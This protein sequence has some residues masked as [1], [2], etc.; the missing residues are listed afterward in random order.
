MASKWIELLKEGKLLSEPQLKI[1]CERVKEILMEESNV[2]PVS[3]P[4][5][6]CGD[7]HGQFYDL[8][9]LFR[10]GGEIPSNRYV[11]LGDYVDRGYHSVETF[12]Y[13][14]CLKLMFPG[15]ITLLRGN[16]ETRYI[17]QQYGMYLEV[18]KK[19]GNSNPWKYFTDLFDYL[20]MAAIIEGK[21]FCVHG[22]LSPVISCMDQI[23][24]I[25][26]FQELPT[27][28]PF[29]DLLWSDP[30]ERDVDGWVPSNRG[31]GWL[32]GWKV[33][34]EF[35]YLNDLDLICRSHQLVMEGFKTY[36]RDNNLLTVWSA[37]NYT[38][39]MGNKA[40]IMKVDHNLEKTFEF[41]SA[42]PRSIKS[43]PPQETLPYFL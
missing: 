39:R 15:H 25:N 37:P 17:S 27:E 33:V 34:K 16:H 26:R 5:V 20:P 8:L 38:Y 36:F 23:R 1:L 3:A 14:L 2:Q 22:G 40:T 9:E 18:T 30:E 6:I 11:F 7:I 42:D 35:N 4:V 21:I 10:V 41:F 24:M 43:I 29:S 31:A 28:G 19:Y 32:F 12:S 13:L